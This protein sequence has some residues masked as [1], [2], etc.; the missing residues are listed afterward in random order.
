MCVE[1]T[2]S[3]GNQFY[4]DVNTGNIDKK[5]VRKVEAVSMN[6]ERKSMYFLSL[7]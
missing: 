5:T 3:T 6:P 4:V 7:L 1:W 2:S